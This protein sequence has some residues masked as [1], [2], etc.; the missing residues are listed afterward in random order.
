MLLDDSRPCKGGKCSKGRT[1]GYCIVCGRQKDDPG[2]DAI[3]PPVVRLDGELFCAERRVLGHVPESAPVAPFL[4]SLSV[5][6]HSV[7][8]MCGSARTGAHGLGSP[9]G[10]A[11][12]AVRPFGGTRS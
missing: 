6:P 2:P 3:S 5:G 4:A 10:E 1:L 8:A 12:A 11:P 9:N 7:G